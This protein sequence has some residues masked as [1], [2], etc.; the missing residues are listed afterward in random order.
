MESEESARLGAALHIEG[1]K[2]QLSF[3]QFMPHISFI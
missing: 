1:H 3:S 2:E